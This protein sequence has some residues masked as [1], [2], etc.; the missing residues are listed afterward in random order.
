MSNYTSTACHIY[1]ENK[2]TSPVIEKNDFYFLYNIMNLLFFESPLIAWVLA[3]VMIASLLKGNRTMLYISGLILCML[4]FFYRKT[5]VDVD[6]TD[7]IVV[8][9]ASGRVTNVRYING[10][11]FISVFLSV[12]DE[13]HQ[14]YPVSG[15]IIYQHYD[16]T[17]KFDLVVKQ[18]KSRKNEKVEQ[19]IKMANGTVV[20]V[21]QIA[22]FLP[23]CIVYKGKVNDVVRAGQY[24][25]MIKFGSRVDLEI[26]M[27]K[28]DMKRLSI[29]QGQYI[30]L[31]D[32]VFEFTL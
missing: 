7:N 8:S 29:K 10:R 13:H 6:S 4:L 18:E 27:S 32:V 22:G 12:F 5:S 14:V 11:C 20:T 25:G 30:N 19:K 1:D 9:P 15:E 3:S 26:P 2:K 16:K 23:R 31:G 28:T 17:G 24:L 21:R